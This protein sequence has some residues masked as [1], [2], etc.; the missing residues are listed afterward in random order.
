MTEPFVD[1]VII[2]NGVEIA[3]APNIIP[4]ILPP[5][6]PPSARECNARYM[7]WLAQT[8]P[9]FAWLGQVPESSL[10]GL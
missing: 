8:K 5:G 3:R 2:C 9:E 6:R 10:K 4:N 7:N 1:H